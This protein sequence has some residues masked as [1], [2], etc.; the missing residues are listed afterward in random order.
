MGD[1]VIAAC[2]PR[3]GK[4]DMLLDLAREHLP[5][6]RAQGPATEW[7]AHIM[8][9]MD[10]TI[11]E[12]FEWRSKD[13]IAQAHANPFVLEMWKRSAEACEYVPLVTVSEAAQ[14]FAGFTPGDFGESPG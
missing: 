11:I 7:P 14:M 12:V 8:R 3:P 5:V 2:R 6:P 13:A 4:E 10:G 1:F 9:T